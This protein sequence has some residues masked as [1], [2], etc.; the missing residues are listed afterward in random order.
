M[1]FLLPTLF[2]ELFILKRFLSSSDHEVS[3]TLDLF[4]N[5]FSIGTA[6]VC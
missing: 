3:F 4:P 1:I 2:P 6:E 5:G